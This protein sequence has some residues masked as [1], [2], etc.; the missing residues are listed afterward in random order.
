MT[1]NK[2]LWKITDTCLDYTPVT[3]IKNAVSKQKAEEIS[4]QVLEYSQTDHSRE[5][6][7][8]NEDNNPGCWRGFPLI[9]PDTVPGLSRENKDL[10]QNTIMEAGKHYQ[11]SWPDAPNVQVTTWQRSM[12]TDE[13]DVSIW[14][15]INQKGAANMIHNHHGALFSGVLYFQA[16]DT[17]SI[18]LYPD[19]FLTGHTHP[20]WPYKGSMIHEPD[21]GDLL[22]F[23]AYLLHDVESN[24]N[25]SPRINCAFNVSLV[26]RQVP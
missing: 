25:N 3:I 13:Y 15:N 21:D 7:K 10:I 9:A 4:K 2:F 23:P 20:M 16:K 26:P 12:F 11:A 18:R 19:N 5:F 22:L 14:F 24:P 17:G 1:M 6:Q 8:F